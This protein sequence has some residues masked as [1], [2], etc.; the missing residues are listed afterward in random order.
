MLSA[1]NPLL[2]EHSL[3]SVPAQK[4]RWARGEGEAWARG[5]REA[6]ARG[7]GEAWARGGRE[8]PGHEEGERP[9]HEANVEC[10]ANKGSNDFPNSSW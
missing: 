1:F 9:G 7:G 6:W 8:R 5:G 2:A 10:S 3:K 4:Q